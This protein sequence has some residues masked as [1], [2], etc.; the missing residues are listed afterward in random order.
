MAL[1]E[2]IAAATGEV[3]LYTDADSLFLRDTVAKTVRW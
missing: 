2:G 1:N 3:V